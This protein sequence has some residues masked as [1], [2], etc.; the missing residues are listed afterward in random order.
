MSVVNQFNPNTKTMFVSVNG[1]E[2]AEAAIAAEMEVDREKTEAPDRA[3][4]WEQAAT[5]LV[6]RELLLQESALEAI[7]GDEEARIE[8]L[9]SRHIH[10]PVAVDTHC[11][12]FFDENPDRF[13]SPDLVE[14]RHILLAAP[15]FDEEAREQAR[16]EALRL[17]GELQENP[18]RFDDLANTYSAC[19]SRE[20]GGR[21]G[22]LSSGATVPEFENALFALEAGLASAPV[23]SRYGLHVVWVDH[24][25]AGEPLPYE[26]VKQAISRFLE[27][28]VFRKSLS[29]YLQLLA[30]KA[31]ITGVDIKSAES[32]L[33]Q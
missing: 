6:L 29:Q 11:R 32:P 30:G 20:Q 33:L 1:V 18:L 15:P 10:V 5:A 4:S 22:Q 9:L 7:E 21:L 19:P 16:Y 24:K 3:K 13:R 31:R 17:I 2:I 8:A 12:R 26:H 27:D 14:A 28:S 25:I 23:E